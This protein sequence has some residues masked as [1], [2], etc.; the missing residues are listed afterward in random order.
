MGKGQASRAPLRWPVPHAFVVALVAG[1][2]CELGEADVVNR[3]P[4]LGPI[5]SVLP[6]RDAA[7]GDER[8][9][10]DLDA[11]VAEVG[12]PGA[13][14]RDTPAPPTD[15]AVARDGAETGDVLRK[16]AMPPRLDGGLRGEAGQPS[17]E[18]GV[19][20]CDDFEDSA[21]DWLWSGQSWEVTE[22][23]TAEDNQVLAPTEAVACSAY[24]PLGAWQDMTVEVRVRVLA[25][26]QR[27]SANRAE[28][29]ARYQDAEHCYAVALRG[30]GK[31]GLRRNGTGFGT[32]ASVT[33]AENEWH[34]LKIMVSGPQEAVVVEGYLDGVLLTTAS[35]TSGA[36]AG[37]IGTVGVGVYGGT[38]AV[39]DDLEV[40]TP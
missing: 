11:P 26:G 34:S 6:G 23:E 27:S 14:A 19:V 16:D 8:P 2:G 9:D 10:G 12:G 1:L 38:S 35:D 36:L 29:Y 17:C 24:V 15:A 18:P 37:A 32:A 33:V 28:V 30:D 5:T 40:S 31:L 22:E 39:F 21:T 7:I 4:D 13:D 3:S 20:F 25:F